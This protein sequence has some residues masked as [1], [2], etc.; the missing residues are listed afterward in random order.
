MTD[1]ADTDRRSL[2]S[3]ILHL[4]E[5]ALTAPRAD[6]GSLPGLKAGTSR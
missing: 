2:D 4:L 3:E 5:I 6:T 1:Q